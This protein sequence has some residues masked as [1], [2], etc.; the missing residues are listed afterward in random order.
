MGHSL[1]TYKIIDK[2]KIYI[3]TDNKYQRLKFKQT[4]ISIYKIGT[5]SR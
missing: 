3:Y 4:K 2:A 5:N 1:S